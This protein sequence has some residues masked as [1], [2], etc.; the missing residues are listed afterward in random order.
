MRIAKYVP[1]EVLVL[2]VA[3]RSRGREILHHLALS[4]REDGQVGAVSCSCEGFSY[5]G[6]C[7]H[8]RS[9]RDMAG[10]PSR[11]KG[12]HEA[13]YPGGPL[14]LLT[15]RPESLEKI[16]EGRKTDGGPTS[17]G[18]AKRRMRRGS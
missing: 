2:E 1:V 15:S 11:R 18:P 8:L 16:R 7:H 12:R 14:M 4:L 17:S 3:S 9:L 13:G 10:A 5:R 6:A